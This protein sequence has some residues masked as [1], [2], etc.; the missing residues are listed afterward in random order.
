GTPGGV[1]VIKSTDGGQSWTQVNNGLD[2]L[3]VGTLFMHPQ[4]ASILLAGTGNNQYFLDA[5]VYRSADGGASWEQ[6]LTDEGI[7]AVELA[8]SDPRIAYAGSAGSVFRSADGG[9][10]WEKVCGGP[11][12]W[13]PPGVRAGFPIDF[14]VDPADPNRIFANNYG[15]GNFLSTD[16]ARTWTVASKG[17]TGAQVRDIAVDPTD[18]ATVFAAARSGLFVS[19]DAGENWTGLNDPPVSFLEWYAVSID[20]TDAQHV[21]SASN[22]EGRIRESFDGART[23]QPVG[24]QM[25]HGMSWRAFAW[26]PSNARRV[27]AGTS[28]YFSAGTFD[29]RMPAGGI[30]ASSDGG[31]TWTEANDNTSRNANVIDLSVDPADAETVYAATGNH[32]LLKTTDGGQTWSALTGGLPQSQPVLAVAVPPAQANVVYAGFERAGVY[33]SNNSGQSWQPLPAGLN[34]EAAISHIVFDPRDAQVIYIAD[35]LS[36]V[37]R[38]DN[39]GTTWMALNEGLRVRAVNALALSANGGHL[40]AATEGEGVFRLDLTGTGPV[41][42]SQGG[43]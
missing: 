14:Q 28:A 32:G 15:G 42:S 2:N 38:S 16:G 1:G 12:G 5:G 17:Y 9:L 11:E 37:Y 41:P 33:R 26:V 7:N 19:T 35:K 22:W 24:P 36:G 3:Y 8:L 21:L 34:P 30:H 10:T 40:Y 43:L 31:T 39:G 25:P 18:A 27:Y 23:S 29:D 6:T 20:P 4:N 13:G